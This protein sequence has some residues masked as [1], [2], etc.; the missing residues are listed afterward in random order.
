MTN[1]YIAVAS[2]LLDIQ[3][4]MAALR[5]WEAERPCE[6]ALASSEPFCIDTLNFNQ[7]VQ[8]VFLERMHELIEQRAPLPV[9]CDISP[10]AEEYFG[11][12]ALDAH[13][14]IKKLKYVDDLISGRVEQHEIIARL[15]S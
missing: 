4:E 5:I 1:I 6:E 9:Q 8:F 3:A 13:Q 14:L 2:E 10:L 11:K 12:Q 7:W 15:C